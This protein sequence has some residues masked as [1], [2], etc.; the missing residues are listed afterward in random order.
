MNSKNLL[1]IMTV[2]SIVMAIFMIF[3]PVTFLNWFLKTAIPAEFPPEMAAVE[4]MV[5]LAKL[6]FG[7]FGAMLAGIAVIGGLGFFASDATASAVRKNVIM[8]MTFGTIIGF[9]LTLVAMLSGK[10][11]GFGW[12]LVVIWALLAVAQGYFGFVKAED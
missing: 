3:L 7:F 8:G 4:D 10:F 5:G 6:G 1:L 9:V 11:N 12:I 2:I